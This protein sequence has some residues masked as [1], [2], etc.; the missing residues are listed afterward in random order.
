MEIR[1]VSILKSG[2]Y[3]P[4]KYNYNSFN[5]HITLDKS[6]S[7]GENYTIFID[8]IAKPNEIKASENQIITDDKGLYFI[9][10]LG[11]DKKK[12]TQIWTHGETECNSGWFPTIDKPNQ[13]TTNEISMTVRI[14]TRHCRTVCW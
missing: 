14:N 1:E 10:P 2:R 13:K 8:Y 7:G 5:L 3:I 9:N 11:K 4:L 12:P 6:Y